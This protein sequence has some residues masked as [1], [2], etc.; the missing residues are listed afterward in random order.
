MAVSKKKETGNTEQSAMDAGRAAASAATPKGEPLNTDRKPQAGK[1]ISV[2]I[3]PIEVEYLRRT[4]GSYGV[5][6]AGGIKIAVHYV[7]RELEAG[8]LDLSKGGL[9]TGERGR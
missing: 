6:L 3:D 7:A 4:F 2:R 8:R 5:T 1:S 9:H